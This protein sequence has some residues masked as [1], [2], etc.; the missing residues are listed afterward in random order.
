MVHYGFCRVTGRYA[1]DL[2][3]HGFS[4][5]QCVLWSV[6]LEGK[7]LE[8]IH[9]ILVWTLGSASEGDDYYFSRMSYQ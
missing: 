1:A 9:C 2:W 3:E 4:E 7:H 8:M 6:F 5:K